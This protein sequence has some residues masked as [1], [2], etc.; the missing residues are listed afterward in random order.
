[1]AIPI[2]ARRRGR[3]GG[4]GRT[5]AL[6]VVIAFVVLA[7]SLKG[8][9]TF[10]TDFL[11]FRSLGLTSVWRK[12][13]GA[14]IVL[15]LIFISLFFVLC[16]V[17]LMVADRIAPSR[18]PAGPEEDLL[19]AWHAFVDRR[20]RVVRVAVAGVLALIAGAGVSSQWNE[21]LLFTHP[22][23]F[24]E[25]DPLFHKD[26]GFYVFKLPFLTFLTNWL[27]F[28]F[29][30]ILL[31]TAVQHYL[32]GGIRLQVERDYVTPQVKAHLS[33]LLGVLALV[34]AA[35]Y[36]LQRYE[37]VFSQRGVIDGA[38]YTDVHV[39]RPAI[40]LLLL[41]SVLSFGLLIT[42]IFRRGW[43]LPAVTV[44]LWAFCAIVAGNVYP[45]FVQRFRVEP[46]QSTK[47]RV[48]VERNIAATRSAYG[49]DNVEQRQFDYEADPTSAEVKA[50]AENFANTRLVTPIRVASTLTALQGVKDFYKFGVPDLDRYTIGGKQTQVVIGV[51]ELNENNSQSWENAHLAYTHGDGVVVA[52]A[53]EVDRGL[54]DF[55]VSGLPPQVAPTLDVTINRSQVYFG[56]NLGGYAIINTK[57]AE[58]GI[59]SRSGATTTSNFSDTSDGESTGVEIGSFVRR[60]AFALRFGSI[61]PLISNFVTSSSRVIFKRDVRERVKA[62]APFLTFDSDPYPVLVDG[63]TVYVI[64][65]YTTT[66]KYPYSQRVSGVMSKNDLGGVNY[67]RNSV[68][69]VV[70]AY[71][72]S[73][74]LYAMPGKDPLLESYEKAFPKLFTPFDQMPQTL[75]QHLRYPTDLFDVQTAMWGRYHVDDP[76]VL[77][78]NSQRW[79][80]ASD[81]GSEPQANTSTAATGVSGTATTSSNQRMAPYYTQTQLPGETKQSFV[82]TRSFSPASAD[83]RTP[84]LTGFMVGKSDV[85]DYGKLVVY[86]VAGGSPRAPSGV[87]NRIASTAD[88]SEAI[89][90]L[91]ARGQGSK[92]FYGDL[93]A[94]PVGNSLVYVRSL[95]VQP[96]DASTAAVIQKIIISVAD[97][98][99]LGDTFADALNLAFPGTNI[100]DSVSGGAPA[101]PATGTGAGTGSASGAS[102]GTGTTG[103]TG[104]TGATGPSTNGGAVSSANSQRLTTILDQITQKRALANKAFGDGKFADYASLQSEIDTLL[105]EMQSILSGT[106]TG[107]SAST[108]TSA[109]TSGGASPGATGS[110][111]SGTPITPSGTGSSGPSAS[112]VVTTTT[113]KLT[114]A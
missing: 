76:T 75:Q 42:N 23:K 78:E 1:M 56:E 45:A 9:A 81:P 96:E 109:G 27:F 63:R 60:A 11:W 110:G 111:S 101:T 2:D 70:D 6:V 53:D 65:G 20:A 95:Y 102:G 94:V 28:S 71:N 97:R 59:D 92:V 85:G 22:V 5:I 100:G 17:N 77:L 24:N 68:K 67:V 47:E 48:Y 40:Y 104:S 61:D 113:R 62:I 12:V 52:P 32:N 10:Y 44:G 98:V 18:R 112:S 106:P 74:V 39:Q 103:S 87:M 46:A 43:Q 114:S 13:L 4:R 91:N 54:P 14:R 99:V 50:S 33:L 105:T 37:L 88:V 41:I 34:K 55:L 72:G 51:R 73:V 86:N 66:D 31:I 83:N 80:V 58:I 30:M 3:F 26:I 64:D 7:L 25:V 29:V 108:T 89:T 49:L 38:T 107:S 8:I 15:A 93:V 35:D 16:W 21:W 36:W 69:A 90:L 57:R 84:L 19:E 79:D 82:I